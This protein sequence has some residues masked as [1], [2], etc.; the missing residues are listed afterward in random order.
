MSHPPAVAGLYAIADTQYLDERR[1]REAVG[2]AI[3]G[4]ARLIQYRDKKHTMESRLAQACEIAA[5]CRSAGVLFLI[6]DDIMLAKASSAD[7]VHLGRDD[8]AINVARAQLGR[9]AIIGASCYN[10]VHLAELAVSRGATYVAFGRFFPSRTK[11]AAVQMTTNILRQAR[12]QIAVPIV[13]I[14]G[15]TPE[16]GASLITAGADALAVIDG[17]FGQ[18]DIQFAASRFAQLFEPKT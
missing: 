13:A 14:G 8:E 16:N 5:I 6:N 10:E 11:P 18:A 12:K 9:D 15:I 3:R 2:S 7:G 17:V 1:L 4:G